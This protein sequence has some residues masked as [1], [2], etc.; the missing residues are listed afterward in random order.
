M[1]QKEISEEESKN[2]DAENEYR[3]FIR[4]FLLLFL[5]FIITFFLSRTIFSEGITL[6][7]QSYYG[8]LTIILL[9][10]SIV[11]IIA[12]LI[13][14]GPIIFQYLRF[15]REE[16]VSIDYSY[17]IRQIANPIKAKHQFRKITLLFLVIS[18]IVIFIG[19]QIMLFIIIF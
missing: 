1:T 2:T 9:L 15:N 10:P 18:S 8:L 19:S 16:I 14:S 4:L 11:I 17:F 5:L 12:L 3:L 6:Y 7:D 13:Y